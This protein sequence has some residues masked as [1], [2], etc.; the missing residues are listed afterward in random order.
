M[1]LS[2]PRLADDLYRRLEEEIFAGELA[3]GCR[4]DETKLA[5]R[6]GVSR[7]PV[8]EALLQLASSGL[9]EL[10]PRQGAV[11]A[12]ITVQ[13]LLQ[14][15]EVMAELD[16]DLSHNVSKS[17]DEFR[18]SVFDLVI[19][20]C[21]DA[22]EEMESARV[23]PLKTGTTPSPTMIFEY[24]AESSSSNWSTDPAFINISS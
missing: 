15:F 17:T 9:I 6:F 24:Q 5:G 14:M 18:E 2:S 3:P 10:R 8:R 12:K 22:S 23:P 19:T 21:G 11:V 7:T 16:I 20:V 1:K 4:L 13:E